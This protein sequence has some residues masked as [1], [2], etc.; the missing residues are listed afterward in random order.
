MNRRLPGT[1]LIALCDQPAP[2]RR[3]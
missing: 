1:L 3:G 2:N